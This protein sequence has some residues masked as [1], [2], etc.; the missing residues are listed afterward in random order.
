MMFILSV[1][2][3]IRAGVLGFLPMRDVLVTASPETGQMAGQSGDD[4]D[5]AGST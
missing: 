4:D 1:G 2:I 3:F 5:D